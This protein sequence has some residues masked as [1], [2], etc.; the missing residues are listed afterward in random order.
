MVFKENPVAFVDESCSTGSIKTQS[1]FFC[2]N[3]RI[4]L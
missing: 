1:S 3:S 4:Y 2:W